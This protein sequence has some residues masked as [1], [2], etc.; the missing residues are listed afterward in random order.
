MA[1]SYQYIEGI[2]AYMDGGAQFPMIANGLSPNTSYLFAA[3][4]SNANG[5]VVWDSLDSTSGP[6]SVTGTTLPSEP[7]ALEASNITGKSASIA[8][9]GVG[10]NN[11]IAYQIEVHPGS[12]VGSTPSS[13]IT[14]PNIDPTLNKTLNSSAIDIDSLNHSSSYTYRVR[15]INQAG[16]GEWSAPY[17]FDTIQAPA[18][19]E[20]LLVD[21]DNTIQISKTLGA[22]EVL[23]LKNPTTGV[24]AQ[25][26]CRD[27]AGNLSYAASDKCSL[28]EGTTYSPLHIDSYHQAHD[29]DSADKD[30]GNITTPSI[31]TQ[32][33]ICVVSISGE[34]DFGLTPA[35]QTNEVRTYTLDKTI[36]P[37]ISADATPLVGGRKFQLPM[38]TV[39][40]QNFACGTRNTA[41]NKA[42]PDWRDNTGEKDMTVIAPPQDP[43]M[44]DINSLGQINFGTNTPGTNEVNQFSINGGSYANAS[45]N[46]H[47]LAVG[48]TVSSLSCKRINDKTNQE[49][50]VVSGTGKIPLTVQ[51]DPSMPTSCSVDD[52]G[53]LNFGSAAQANEINIYT[54]DKTS[55]PITWATGATTATVQLPGVLNIDPATFACSRKN[56]VSEKLSPITPFVAPIAGPAVANIRATDEPTGGT[57]VTF[58]NPTLPAGQTL[59]VSTDGGATWGPATLSGG[60]VVVNIPA[61]QTQD[62]SV[63]STDGTLASNPTTVGSFTG[64]LPAA[65]STRAPTG[66]SSTTDGTTRTCIWT[67][68]VTL[69]NPNKFEVSCDGTTWSDSAPL[70]GPTLQI[71]STG[72]CSTPRYRAS[73]NASNVVNLAGNCDLTTTSSQVTGLTVSNVGSVSAVLTWSLTN[74]A[75]NGYKAEVWKGS[76]ATGTLAWS[77]TTANQSSI[78]LTASGLTSMAQYQARVQGLNGSTTGAWSNVQSFTT[79]FDQNAP[80]PTPSMVGI[81][82]QA[83]GD[84]WNSNTVELKWNPVPW[85]QGYEIKV[86][87]GWRV[88]NRPYG[89]AYDGAMEMFVSDGIIRDY[90]IRVDGSKS[91]YVLTDLVPNNPFVY[92]VSTIDGQWD[93]SAPSSAISFVTQ[94]GLNISK[95]RVV[96]SQWIWWEYWAVYDLSKTTINDPLYFMYGYKSGSQAIWENRDKNDNVRRDSATGWGGGS[97]ESDTAPLWDPCTAMSPDFELPTEQ[98]WKKLLAY[99]A[100][101]GLNN[102]QTWGGNPGTYNWFVASYQ[103]SLIKFL[104]QEDIPGSQKYY[105]GIN[106][107]SSYTAVSW[108]KGYWMKDSRK[109]VMIWTKAPYIVDLGTTEQELES[110]SGRAYNVRCVKKD[111]PIN[112]KIKSFDP[113][114][115]F[116]EDRNRNGVTLITDNKATIYYQY[117]AGTSDIT[118]EVRFAVWEGTGSYLS[119]TNDMV[120]YKENI[121][122]TFGFLWMGINAR[123]THS[124]KTLWAERDTQTKYRSREITIQNLKPNTVYSYKMVEPLPL[125]LRNDESYHGRFKTLPGLRLGGCTADDVWIP[126]VPTLDNKTNGQWWAFWATCDLNAW[127]STWSEAQYQWWSATAGSV[128]SAYPIPATWTVENDPCTLANSDYML[129]SKQN[130]LALNDPTK[131]VPN[132]IGQIY[133]GMNMNIGSG[134]I[135]GYRRS[136]NWSNMFTGRKIY[137]MKD[138]NTEWFEQESAGWPFSV[139]TVPAGEAA[140]AASIRCIQKPRFPSSGDPEWFVSQDG[141][142]PSAEWNNIVFRNGCL[143]FTPYGNTSWVRWVLSWATWLLDTATINDGAQGWLN[144]KSSCSGATTL[145]TVK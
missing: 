142:T 5:E 67:G 29:L 111:Q 10:G 35:L 49:S 133:P 1:T 34:L 30:L 104:L 57:D 110:T 18:T 143:S 33:D 95:N 80:P 23:R 38:G 116:V 43:N 27:T 105:Q 92:T 50:S 127:A 6:T 64:A 55:A 138:T 78:T 40:G 109:V 97:Y 51:P 9:N 63:R 45:G 74:N 41:T 125:A 76:V 90:I 89:G 13:T 58:D 16:T 44:C 17:T 46:P 39:I 91:S 88:D 120:P 134:A 144:I 102:S 131:P 106:E 62:L 2:G 85:A 21:G 103:P 22:G 128:G 117:W 83:I 124:S 98:Q 87:H 113:T 112:P 70:V 129:P 139:K 93:L 65:N 115:L 145:N 32:S 28:P 101:F 69:S 132:V 26:D 73:N 121:W 14:L 53:V 24:F 114:S 37:A 141:F 3:R 25:I 19:P 66:P 99:G 96:T 52:A 59:Q 122:Q 56:T 54:L 4:A 71:L 118:G 15:A 48:I 8:W 36:V 140:R 79:G 136:N 130:F 119:T 12:S 47:Q 31:P 84:E 107:A 100:R 94:D 123:Y 108:A 81:S 68:S 82:G 137:W 126:G 72:A 42:S 60:Q 77:S 75:D 20:V 86:R 135:T 61:G 7:T 11:N